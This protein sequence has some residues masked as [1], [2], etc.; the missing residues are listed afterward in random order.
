MERGILNSI[1]KILSSSI[2]EYG[3]DLD[4]KYLKTSDEDQK[5]IITSFDKIDTCK[6]MCTR[7]FD[8]LK[9]SEKNKKA[10]DMLVPIFQKAFKGKSMFLTYGGELG[11][12]CTKSVFVLA[13]YH[14]GNMESEFDEIQ[15]ILTHKNPEDDLLEYAKSFEQEWLGST[16]I[17]S[18][19]TTY[20]DNLE[21]VDLFKKLIFKTVD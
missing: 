4:A 18:K 3:L 7:L 2:F 15:E 19:M 10:L 5:M 13:L 9:I 21:F 1:N 8:I 6:F 17:R 11:D 14:F 12:I 16:E 20:Q